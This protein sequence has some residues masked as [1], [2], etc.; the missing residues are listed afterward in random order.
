[1]TTSWDEFLLAIKEGDPARALKL[2][3]DEG[4]P[5]DKLKEAETAVVK[6]QARKKKRPDIDRVMEAV[7]EDEMI[8]FCLDCGHEQDCVEPDAR[9]YTCDY[10]GAKRVYGAEELLFELG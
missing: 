4:F 3:A 1:M 8:G 10:C 7:Q 5:A 2:M 6:V 9:G